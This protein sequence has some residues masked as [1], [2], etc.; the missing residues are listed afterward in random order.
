[1]VHSL[2]ASQPGVS[3][4]HTKRH[5]KPVAVSDV[6]VSSSQVDAPNRL[7]LRMLEEHEDRHYDWA[8]N[9][10]SPWDLQHRLQR[11]NLTAS[12]HSTQPFRAA[13]DREPSRL[14]FPYR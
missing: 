13:P 5:K 1:M 8:F 4:S 14:R 12:A 9:P 11:A 3:S 10:I 7:Q 6:G 2:Q